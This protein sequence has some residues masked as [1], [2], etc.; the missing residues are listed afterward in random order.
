[1]KRPISVTIVCSD[2]GQHDPARVLG[3]VGMMLGAEDWQATVENYTVP[4]AEQDSY[5]SLRDHDPDDIHMTDRFR[6]RQCGRDEAI[7]RGN[8]VAA[9]RTLHEQGHP[10][11]DLSERAAIFDNQ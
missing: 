5:T 8:L 3:K 1:V 11:L 7:R 6:C 2:K 4:E 9:A 10:S